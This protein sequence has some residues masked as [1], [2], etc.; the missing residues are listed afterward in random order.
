MSALIVHTDHIVSF[1]NCIFFCNYMLKAS[2]LP[3][4]FMYYSSDVL[5]RHFNILPDEYTMQWSMNRGAGGSWQGGSCPLN[6][7]GGGQ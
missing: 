2:S 6:I 4:C 1:F 7:S 3:K 5:T